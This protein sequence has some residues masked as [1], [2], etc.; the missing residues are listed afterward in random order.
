MNI[1][2]TP[3]IYAQERLT[4]PLFKG[5]PLGNILS[6][7]QGAGNSYISKLI[8]VLINTTLIIGAILFF[9]Y[10]IYGAISVITAGG[11]KGKIESA[12]SH[13]KNALIGIILLI[14]AFAI[15]KLIEVIFGVDILTLDLSSLKLQ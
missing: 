15:T 8:P 3:T 6:G 5:S 14:S 2:L 11:D 1:I 10:L 13:L 4:N 9:F 12:R 7:G